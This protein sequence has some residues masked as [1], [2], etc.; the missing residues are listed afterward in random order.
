LDLSKGAV[1]KQVYTLTEL[2]KLVREKNGYYLSIRFPGLGVRARDRLPLDIA[3]KVV[4][5]LAETTGHT[6][7]IV[8]HENHHG[9]Y[10]FRVTPPDVESGFMFE[11]DVAPLHVT[12][13]RKAILALFSTEQ[14][15][16]IFDT[17]G[18]S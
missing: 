9:V 1:H 4:E 6:T 14:R 17:V 3:R 15:A 7:S 16:E 8:L 13:G 5:A 10:V 2:I 11:G 12:A 18:L